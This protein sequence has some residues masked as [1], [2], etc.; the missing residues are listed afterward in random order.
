LFASGH[1][2]ANIALARA[3]RRAGRSKQ[4]QTSNSAAAH[5]P[6]VLPRPCRCCGGRLIIIETFAATANRTSPD[7]RDNS[8]QHRHLMMP[9]PAIHHPSAARHSGWLSARTA[10]A[11][12]R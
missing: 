3:A 9:S 4:A 1:C 12:C 10:P 5:E 8:S 2:A 6:R 11:Y 7:A